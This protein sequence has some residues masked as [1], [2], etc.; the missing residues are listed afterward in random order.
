MRWPLTILVILFLSIAVALPLNL[1]LWESLTLI[2]GD[3]SLENLTTYF[4]N[5]QGNV[6]LA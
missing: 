5:G 2:P 3:Y 4:W 6:N 1:L